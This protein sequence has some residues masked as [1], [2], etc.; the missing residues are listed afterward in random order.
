MLLFCSN[1]LQKAVISELL[2][3]NTDEGKEYAFD[4]AKRI[5][6]KFDAET[7]LEQSFP[8]VG[9]F[10]EQI[11][12]FARYYHVYA[13]DSRGHGKTPRG[14]KPF[15]ISQFS[16]DLLV[17]MNPH[18][19]DFRLISTPPFIPF[20]IRRPK[21]PSGLRVLLKNLLKS[22][23]TYLIIRFAIHNPASARTMTAA[24]AMMSHSV[25]CSGAIASA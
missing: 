3:L 7:E 24:T 14:N 5:A 13:L 16:D 10:H 8:D 12:E 11:D 23:I 15:T 1:G 2:A 19:I 17:F 4:Y 25:F 6:D 20:T 9:Y 21:K 18:A 22:P